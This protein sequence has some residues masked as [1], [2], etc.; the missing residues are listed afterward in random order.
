MKNKIIMIGSIEYIILDIV[1]IAGDTQYLVKNTNSSEIRIIS[2][3]EVR[4]I[5]DNDKSFIDNA[6]NYLIIAQEAIPI[7]YNLLNTIK[8]DYGNNEEN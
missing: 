1:I 7:V 2:P 4:A 8:K 5:I 3:L 6:L